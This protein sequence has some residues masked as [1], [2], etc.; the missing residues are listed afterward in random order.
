[1]S[2][3]QVHAWLC[4]VESR[5][6]SVFM[7]EFLI[8]APPMSLAKAPLVSTGTTGA[9]G[10][11]GKPPRELVKPTDTSE[12]QVY[13]RSMLCSGYRRCCAGRC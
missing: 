1:M 6:V 5:D 3:K 2:A 7:P 9:V 8:Q 13:E 11:D 4:G 12:I 10:G